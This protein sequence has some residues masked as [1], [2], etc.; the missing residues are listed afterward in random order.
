VNKRRPEQQ[1]RCPECSGDEFVTD[2]EMGE[3]ACRRCGL[4]LQDELLD[5][6]PEWSAFTL[7]ERDAKARAGPPSSLLKFD[8]GLSTTFQPSKDTHGKLLSTRERATMTRLQKR[9]H[10]AKIH[11]STEQNLFQAMNEL[12]RMADKLYLPKYVEEN[13]ALIYRKALTKKLIRG[14]SI[15]SMVA[16]ALYAACRRTKTPQN[17]KTIVEA[18]TKNGKQITKCYRLLHRELQLTMPRDD[19]LKYVPKIASKIG[20]TQQTQNL[21]IDLLHRANKMRIDVGKGPLGM[22]ATALYI[23][24]HLNGEH[25]NQTQVANAADVTTVTIRN[26]CKEL[27]KIL[28]L[29]LKR[30]A[31]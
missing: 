15:N 19:P 9:N 17:L 14:R 12:T 20:L 26:L 4:V 2:P 31:S 18:S 16:A 29:G 21:A 30:E 5:Q 3:I 23:A 25:V 6:T 8:K 22:A 1:E 11:F 13:A 27:N 10:R 7:E 28:G 24:A